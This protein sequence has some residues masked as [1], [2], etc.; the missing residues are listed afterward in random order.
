MIQNHWIWAKDFG[1]LET[2]TLDWLVVSTLNIW[3]SVGIIIPYTYIYIYVYIYIYGKLR[4]MFQINQNHHN[5]L[6]YPTQGPHMA[7]FAEPLCI[8]ESTGWYTDGI[9]LTRPGIL[10]G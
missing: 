7:H 5:Y 6:M 3:K 1:H 9:Q 4:D 10:L 8:G 2:Y